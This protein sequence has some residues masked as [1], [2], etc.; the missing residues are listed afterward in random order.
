MKNTI[1]NGLKT[2]LIIGDKEQGHKAVKPMF[3]KQPYRTEILT[4]AAASVAAVERLKPDVI[5]IHVD[6][7]EDGDLEFCDHLRRDN[8]TKGIP[9]II[10][11]ESAEDHMI[12][13]AFKMGNM[14]YLKKPLSKD[15]LLGK[16]QSALSN[17]GE[18]SSAEERL[19]SAM[20]LARTVCH[21]FNQP[22]QAIS[23]LCEL[24][25]MNMAENDPKHDDIMKIRG[26][27]ERMAGINRRLVGIIRNENHFAE[28]CEPIYELGAK[29]YAK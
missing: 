1:G 12:S 15:R 11:S 5:L 28:G 27:I 24:M 18:D 25:I 6:Q 4:K 19:E 22:M 23:G 26:L 3:Q 17:S 7:S 13:S 8:E 29:G 2:I 10:L 21:E 9:L 20:K 16:I 14:H